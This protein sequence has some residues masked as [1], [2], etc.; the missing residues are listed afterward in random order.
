MCGI[1][2]IFNNESGEHTPA[3]QQLISM[4]AAIRHRGPD[5]SGIYLNQKIGLGHV[6]LSIIDIFSG[7]QPMAANNGQYRIVYNGELFNF[8]EIRHKLEKLGIQFTTQSDTE[9]VLKAYIQWGPSCLQQFNGQFSIAIWDNKKSELFLARDR[10]GIRPLFYTQTSSNFIFC[11][12]IKGIFQLPYVDRKINHKALAQ[13]FTFWTTITPYTPFEQIFELPPG[14]FMTINNKGT[15]Q[16]RYWNL[17]FT[18][19]KS[20]SSI[21]FETASEELLR[22]LK[23]SVKIRL[24]ADV[25]V[26]AYLSGGLDSSITTALIHELS[27]AMLHTFSIGFK[28]AEFDETN[29]QQEVASFFNTQHTLNTCTSAEIGENFPHTIRHAE[30]PIL[31]TGPTPLY[32]LSKS[33]RQHNIKVVITGEGADEILAGYNIFKEDKIRRFWAR[34]PQ[35]DIRPLLLGR[36]YHYLP[37]LKEARPAFLKM[38][39]GFR[40]NETDNPYYSHLIRWH[41]TSRIQHYFASHIVNQL[42]K[43]EPVDEIAQNMAENFTHLSDLGKS[44][45]LESSIF[46]SG[47]LLSSQGDRMS[48][49]NSVECRYPFLDHRLI[50]YAATLPDNYKLN[51]L[52]EKFIL[53]KMMKQKIPDSV[54]NRRKQAYRAPV[55]PCFTSR[56]TPEYISEMLNSTSINNFGYFDPAKTSQLINKICKCKNATEVENMA[57]SGIISTQLLHHFFITNNI[58]VSPDVRPAN[59]TVTIE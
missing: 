12:E 45:Y 7:Q 39:F 4:L 18:Q 33:V 13:I 44:Q 51:C 56:P 5:E 26:A 59:L 50:E 2:G 49:A 16:H 52:T 9:V 1:A 17:P 23:D 58:L 22:L 47:Y 55:S 29:Y 15:S 46:M 41:N 8:P 11:S 3:E 40:L 30:F 42:E 43:Y 35:S 38:F 21:P 31:R 57:L 27:P 14:H 24:R 6:R 37:A 28:E 25:E 36:L 10:L 54:L 19:K 20:D 48:M 32:L 53:K 34:N